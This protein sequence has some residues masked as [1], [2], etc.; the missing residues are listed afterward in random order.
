MNSIFSVFH[1]VIYP[2]KE[3]NH[4]LSYVLIVMP[5]FL[6]LGQSEVLLCDKES[7]YKLLLS[8]V[9]KAKI[10]KNL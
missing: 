10:K 4:H 7:T 2:I 3:K 1:F 8:K 5:K 9:H 6:N